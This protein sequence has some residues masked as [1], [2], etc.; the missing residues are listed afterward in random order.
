MTVGTCKCGGTL[1]NKAL[2]LTAPQRVP[3]DLL[4]CLAL[5]LGR[6]GPPPAVGPAAER[7]VRQAARLL[8]SLCILL[9]LGASLAAAE[10]TRT[11]RV[12]VAPPPDPG[13]KS[14]T[15]EGWVRPDLP[16]RVRFN[17]DTWMDLPTSTGYWHTL[18][19][20]RRHLIETEENGKRH[21][22]FYFR[23]EDYQPRDDLCLFLNGFY[24]TWQLWPWRRTGA[25]CSC[26][27]G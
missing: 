15:F 6:F 27:Q 4:Y 24:N 8:R 3:I 13:S 23:F 16:Y 22:S 7:P 11:A 21:A 2:Q 20:G 18:S 9:M 5:K 1:P 19:L 17:N 25:W 12:C 26:P 10:P 14:G